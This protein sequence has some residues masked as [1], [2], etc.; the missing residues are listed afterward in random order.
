MSWTVY[1][2][3]RD[4]DLAMLTEMLPDDEL[5]FEVHHDG[6]HVLRS[7]EFDGMAEAT[8]VR[9]A[10]AKLLD[11][12]A[13]VASIRNP[14]FQPVTLTGQVRDSAGKNTHVVLVDPVTTVSIASPV[15]VVTDGSNTPPPPPSEADFAALAL[16]DSNVSEALRH[17]R[18]DA[19]WHALYKVYEVVRDDLGGTKRLMSLRPSDPMAL[20][21]FTE[22]ANRSEISGDAARHARLGGQPS[23]R[24]TDLVSARHLIRSLVEAW[25]VDKLT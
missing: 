16:R 4:R 13:G 11:T 20:D 8:D 15:V 2:Q 10:A 6:N 1:V 19:D 22:S 21:T 24:S 3:G 7:T 25:M 5:A 14:G 23:G 9:A 12:A 18:T 17:L